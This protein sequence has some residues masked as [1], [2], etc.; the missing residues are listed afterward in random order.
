MADVCMILEGT[1]PYVTGGVSAWVHELITNLSDISFDVV[2]IVPSAGYAKEI[3]YKMPPNIVSLKCLPI[4]EF[5]ENNRPRLSYFDRK[6]FFNELF[7]AFELFDC[8]DY[9]ALEILSAAFDKY[10]PSAGDILNT[11]DGWRVFD[12]IYK[13]SGGGAPFV[14]FFWTLR[15]IIIPLFN[16]IKTAPPV[17]KCIHTIST[18]YAGLLAA[19]FKI[20]LKRPMILTEHGIYTNERLLE[21]IDAR[22]IYDHNR[23]AVEVLKELPP[24]KKFWINFFMAVGKLTYYYSDEII[25]LYR[26]NQQLQIKL[27]ADAKKCRV[28]PNG[29]DTARFNLRRESAS[30]GPD[31]KVGFVGR[32][33]PIKDVKTL[34]YAARLVVDRLPGAKFLIKGPYDEDMA[35]FEECKTLTSL[36]DLKNSVVF[37]GPGSVHDFYMELDVVVL[38][39]VSEAQPLAVL[40]GNVCRVPAVSTEVGCVTELLYGIDEQDVKIGPS[41]IVVPVKSPVELG[42]AIIKILSDRELNMKM[43]D[44]GLKRVMT[45]YK[46]ED[47]KT[48]YHGIYNS[49]INGRSG[50]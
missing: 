23:D 22:W 10:S 19:M 44:S 6:K 29:I 4:N 3:K 13:K 33:V 12:Y 25:T 42:E 32:V 34:L 47:L 27:G 30:E 37:M 48:K 31:Y 8:D 38:S 21:I 26:G 24:L 5:D 40:E 45:Y 39:S 50:D 14:D 11:Y 20:R 18:G 36:L 7:K 49:Y 28:I 41:G 15:F 9:S 35:Y 46:K 2:T 43:G 16:L 17:S 1:Y